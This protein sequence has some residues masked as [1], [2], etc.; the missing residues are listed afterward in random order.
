LENA[1]KVVV[2]F[3]RRLSTKVKRQEKLDL[4]EESNYR[5]GK[6]LKKYTEKMLY[7]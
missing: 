1:K 5:R 3:E 6:L 2:D 4:V 7:K